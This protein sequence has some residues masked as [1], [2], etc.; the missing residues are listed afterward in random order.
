MS[1][2]L[3]KTKRFL[4]LLITQ[5]LG[6]LND[7]LFKNSL[8]TLVA[9]KMTEQSD[10]LSNLIAG[11]FILP[12]FLFSATAGQIADKYPKERIARILKLLE[13]LLMSAVALAY[14]I[15]SLP[16]LIIILGLMGAQ[17]AFFGPIKYALL[18]QQLQADELIAANAY[19]EATTY[20]A[21]LFGLILGTLLPIEITIGLLIILAICGYF[22]AIFI[23]FAPSAR[24]DAKIN[25]NIF[26]ALKDNFCFIR[27]YNLIFTSILG[28]TWFWIIG[29]LVAV[30]IYPLAAQIINANN[31]VIAFFLI[32]FSIGVAVGS[33]ACSKILKGFINTTYVPL[34]AI[35]MGV[36]LFLLYLFTKNYPTA[37]SSVNFIGFLQLPHAFAI[38]FNLFLL[39]FWGG[40]YIIPLNALMQSRAPRAYVATVIAGNNIFNSLGM[41]LIAIFAIIFLAL[42]F[43]IPQLFL[44]MAIFSAMVSLYICSLLPDALTRSLVQALLG[45]LFK[46]RVSG[47]NNF[48]RA[49]KKVLIVSNHVSLLDGV[50][51]AA[52]MP[53]RIT[54][55]INT[56]WTQKWFIPIIRLLVDFYPIDPANPLSLRS[57]IEEI[58]KGRKVMMFP[59][60]R[61]T[62]T[63]NIMKVYEGAGIIAAKS[64]A[65]ILPVRIN[66]AQYSK[67][68]YIKNK[69]RTQ[70]FPKITLNILEAKK[71][72]MPENG[73]GRTVRYLIAKQLYELMNNMVYQTSNRE[74]NIFNSLLNAAKIH[75]KKHQII[76]DVMTKKTINYQEL[77]QNIYCLG[78]QIKID[79]ANKAELEIKNDDNIEFLSQ[80]FAC[81]YAG[82]TAII[83]EASVNELKIG[84]KARIWGYINYL[85]KKMIS[86]N[87]NKI[88]IK[89]ASNQ[90]SFSHKALQSCCQQFRGAFAFNPKDI[91]INP[92]ANTNPFSLIYGSLFSLLNGCKSVMYCSS[93]YSRIIP[94]L[95][96]DYEATVII[97]NNSLFAAWGE[98]AH[99][100]D[101]F[102][103]KA[104]IS[105]QDNLEDDTFNLWVKK[106]G[107]RILEGYFD[108]SS[109]IMISINTPIY[110]QIGSLGC[111]M[112]GIDYQTNPKG[113]LLLKANNLQENDWYNLGKDF[114]I[115]D[116]GFL[117][118]K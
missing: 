66:G 5:F 79:F 111:I 104:A 15:K 34:S 26:V 64:G 73:N 92:L 14:V 29:A 114:V 96:Y 45:F 75:G 53:E 74:E 117:I 62:V 31:Q 67:F 84:S 100:Y 71:F 109:N 88:A 36:S 6:A 70:W 43:S 1:A 19:V 103:L 3:L 54:F 47:I 59:E 35:G 99:S 113:E 61:V 50:L 94:E 89:F 85:R 7:N 42:G 52:F 90:Q 22:A 39:A 28:A 87:P 107:I 86:N 9:I 46:S 80:L 57:L 76:T 16:L 12:F 101:F 2:N 112:S 97:G 68:S 51:L 49:G 106:F 27:K 20:I 58:K 78:E 98:A 65:K 81:Q 25:K 10:I 83:S 118:R 48:R 56:T 17:S 41:V 69:F 37:E 13:I 38:S 33:F 82:K 18:P 72:A 116:Q 32:I 21:I 95:C 24:V 110:N 55:A 8:L 23:P 102:N 93:D 60:G 30:Q 4:P 115:S 63:G 11:L 108:K 44:T 40:M 105:C 91:M 77:L